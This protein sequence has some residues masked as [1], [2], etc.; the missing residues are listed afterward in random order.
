L[1]VNPNKEVIIMT[2]QKEVV[3]T[4]MRFPCYEAAALW[5][6]PFLLGIDFTTP[7]GK[8]RAVCNLCEE[9]INKDTVRV[10]DGDR[11]VCRPCYMANTGFSDEEVEEAIREDD[12]TPIV[13]VHEQLRLI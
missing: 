2:R 10:L 4:I 12:S 13:P 5:F 3:K 8:R 9:P 6:G 11:L 1:A 7:W